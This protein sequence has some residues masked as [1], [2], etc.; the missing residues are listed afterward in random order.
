MLMIWFVSLYVLY[1]NLDIDKNSIYKILRFE[2]YKIFTK[3]IGKMKRFNWKKK[4]TGHFQEFSK[5]EKKYNW[6]FSSIFLW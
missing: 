3:N 4:S 5:Y 6:A 1:T 2:I